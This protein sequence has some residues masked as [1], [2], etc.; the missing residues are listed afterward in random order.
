MTF[1]HSTV[2]T[3]ESYDRERAT[4]FWVFPHAQQRRIVSYDFGD[5][6]QFTRGEVQYSFA[7][8]TVECG[9]TSSNVHGLVAN[10]GLFYMRCMKGSYSSDTDQLSAWGISGSS[11]SLV[12]QGGT[13]DISAKGLGIVLRWR[14][15]NHCRLW[16]QNVG[17]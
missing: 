10:A 15:D 17:K 8:S 11:S 7:S 9:K 2:N 5:N 6:G 4:K 14:E 13:Q 16:I 12:P 1:R 3:V